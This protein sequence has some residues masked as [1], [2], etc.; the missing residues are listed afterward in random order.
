MNVEDVKKA[1]VN[2][3]E[4]EGITIPD[5]PIALANLILDRFVTYPV[6]DAFMPYNYCLIPDAIE[7]MSFLSNKTVKSS[8]VKI[9]KHVLKY[10]CT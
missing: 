5:D 4:R 8:L 7:Q 1:L 6:G 2:Q 9:A 3:L 10:V